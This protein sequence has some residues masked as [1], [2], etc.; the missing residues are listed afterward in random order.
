[1]AGE[2]SNLG[3]PPI[4]AIEDEHRASPARGKPRLFVKLALAARDSGLL[5]KI[6]DELW[7]TLCVLA[8]YADET[9]T[10]YP[11]QETLA[12]ALGVSRQTVNER[13]QRLKI[14]RFEEQPVLSVIGRPR[15]APSKSASRWGN[16][17]YR[18]HSI[19]G[20][21][22]GYDAGEV[23]TP[24][25]AASRSMS[26]G[27]DMGKPVSMSASADIDRPVSAPADTAAGDTNKKNNDNNVSN[28]DN[29][30][31]LAEE[32]DQSKAK[33]PQLTRDQFV[34]AESLAIQVR[35]AIGQPENY[36]AYFRLAQIAVTE[37]DVEPFHVALSL[38]KDA[39][40][41]G[42]I[43][44]TP[45]QYFHAA[46]KRLWTERAGDEV[47]HIPSCE[48]SPEEIRR[49]IQLSPLAALANSSALAPAN[50]TNGAG[51]KR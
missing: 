4:H 45:S 51:G 25:C 23:R 37:N 19:A 12:Q 29:V 50:V 28:V 40:H 11:S 9:G 49:I 32:R 26:A 7:K 20:L 33:G 46:L 24:A 6:P 38:T 15:G 27:A 17:V 3:H 36:P 44:T 30:L 22:F 31:A 39:M 8:T 42:K 34:H 16:N 10:C 47:P 14:F 13:I 2:A 41:R 21:K 48:E 1:M 18:V 43:R 5:A 35:E